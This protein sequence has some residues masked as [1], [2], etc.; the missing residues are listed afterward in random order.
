MERLLDF[1]VITL[2][3]VIGII[4][5]R[6]LLRRLS[7]GKVDMESFCTLYSLEK[8]PVSGE[9]EFY[10]VSPDMIK[11]EFSIWKENDKVVELKN[12]YFKKGGH[13]VRFDSTTL[14]D[15]EYFFGLVTSKQRTIK[16]F[17]I[18]NN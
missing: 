13:I 5:Y 15:G 8:N 14:P 12:D 11:V 17:K 6:L 16:R 9:V 4:L 10:F 7:K 2:F 3:I 18:Q 1:L